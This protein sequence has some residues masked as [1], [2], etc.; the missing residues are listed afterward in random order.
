MSPPGTPY[1]AH[2]GPL[3]GGS[4][5]AICGCGHTLWGYRYPGAHPVGMPSG[6]GVGDVPPGVY[7]GTTSG[8]L[9]MPSWVGTNNVIYEHHVTVPQAQIPWWHT[10]RMCHL[11]AGVLPSQLLDITW[12][13]GYRGRDLCERSPEGVSEYGGRGCRGWCPPE[14]LSGGAEP[15]MWWCAVEGCTMLSCYPR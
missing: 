6:E 4:W 7:S 15:Q 3:L 13:G 1:W 12:G 14:G 10:L 2:S 5:G 11:R 9:G 8:P